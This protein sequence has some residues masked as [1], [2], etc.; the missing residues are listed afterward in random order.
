LTISNHFDSEFF[1]GRAALVPLLR[2]TDER[3]ILLPLD[4]SKLPF[5][6]RRSFVINGETAGT[7]RGE[8]SHLT[9]QQVL[10]CVEGIIEVQ[11]RLEDEEIT[12]QLR[13]HSDGLLIGPGIWSRQTYLEHG[14]ILLAFASEPYDPDSYR[15]ARD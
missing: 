15:E 13:P 5:E 10:I 1:G 9:T 2:Y 7:V 11:M 4:F 8:H 3:G 14:S 6:P 12:L